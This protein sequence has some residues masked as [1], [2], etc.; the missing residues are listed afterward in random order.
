AIALILVPFIIY[1]SFFYIQFAVL[2]QSGPGDSFMSPAFQETL[3]GNEM[4]FNSKKIHYYNTIT[5]KHKGTKVFL[6][7]HPER[8]PPT[9]ADGRISSQGW[10]HFSLLGYELH[11]RHS[12]GQQVIGYG[13]NDTNN[14]W[15]I[16]PTKALPETGRGRIVR[17]DDV[18]QLLHIN[19]QTYLL[20]HDVASPLMPTTKNSQP[21]QGRP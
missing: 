7:S 8:Y 20:T 19:T 16:L 9:Y 12:K 1:L 14:F 6:Y 4:L 17:N 21:G 15:K 11:S 18:I 10:A 2:P 13:H 5:L 3:A